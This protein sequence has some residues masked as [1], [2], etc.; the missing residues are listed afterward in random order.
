[1]VTAS[2]VDGQEENV[3]QIGVDKFLRKPIQKNELLLAILRLLPPDLVKLRKRH[4]RA[5]LPITTVEERSNLPDVIRLQIPQAIDELEG[6]WAQRIT[7]ISKAI[8]L[9][10]V[11]EV[12]R[13][14]K[15]LGYRFQLKPI[16]QWAQNILVCIENYEINQIVKM[17]DQYRSVVQKT[18]KDGY[19]MKL[20]IESHE[21]NPS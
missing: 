15:K 13:E 8:V 14:I 10:E 18:K 16:T 7:E 4:H 2:V 6:K 21:P 9:D 3:T 17:L 19:E 11:E 12:C 1:M 20:E 5:E